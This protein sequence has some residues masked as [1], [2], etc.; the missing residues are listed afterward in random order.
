MDPTTFWALIDDTRTVGEGDPERH[1]EV[2]RCRLERMSAEEILAFERLWRGYDARAYRW[3]LW[4]A[5]YLLNGGCDDRCFEHFRSYVIGLGQRVYEDALA[6]ADSLV[7]LAQGGPAAHQF[8]HDAEALGYAA[9]DAYLAV[10]GHD[11]PDIGPEL[12]VE[13]AGREWDE[14]RPQDAA[15]R[16]AAAVGWL[17]A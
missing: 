15:P 3:E 11:V 5:A 1:A 10:A 8:A 7:F 4:A 12:P 9:A 16:I 13:P 6:D 2:L 17:E 14:E